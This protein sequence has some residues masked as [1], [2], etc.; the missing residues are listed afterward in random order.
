MANLY[1]TKAGNDTTGDGSI[2][3]PWLT[4]GKANSSSLSPADIVNIGDG[5]YAENLTAADS[6][7][8]GNVIT[9]KAINSRLASIQAQI[10]GNGQEYLT[11]DGIKYLGDGTAQGSIRGS[12]NAAGL[13]NI[14]W[15][16]CEIFGARRHAFDIIPS[17]D[18]G[19]QSSY[20]DV[21]IIQNCLMDQCHGCLFIHA[22]NS[23]YL[24]NEMR[25][26]RSHTT[27]DID[28]ARPM[29]VDNLFQGN[30]CHSTDV[31]NTGTSHVDCVQIFHN[32]GEL[33]SGLQILK[34]FFEVCVQGIFMTA[35][36][37]ALSI[38]DIEIKNNVFIEPDTGATVT[39]LAAM[40]FYGITN[41]DIDHNHSI[42]KRDNLSTHIRFHGSKGSGTAVSSG[43][44]KN[45]TFVR[46]GS[47]SPF[48]A[49][50]QDV[51]ISSNISKD[52]SS[53]I[54]ADFNSG[55]AIDPQLIDSAGTG[56][57]AL[58]TYLEV[59][60]TWRPVVSTSRSLNAASD[61]GDLGAEIAVDGGGPPTD[62]TPPVITL[63]GAAEINIPDTD[64]S[65]TDAG[66]TCSDN[67]DGELVMTAGVHDTDGVTANL[68]TPGTYTYD[69]D[70]DDAAA[71]SAVQVTRTVNIIATP[72]TPA[73]RYLV[74]IQLA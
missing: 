46:G 3:T 65:Y 13:N 28:Y 38:D 72:P 15:N 47:G 21:L 42:F 51:V 9:W 66:A 2:G 73:T 54:A 35:R 8:A 4:L 55:V 20:A 18:A 16:D 39:T 59:D 27:G 53:G 6:G 23:S 71:N 26:M 62:T 63:I 22:Q 57:G 34:N 12:G 17:G 58:G 67:L 40:T 11:F 68:G 10:V 25:D 50:A 49:G 31:A 19:T 14:T 32:N 43:T 56:Y 60:A 64:V 45:C 61:G 1:V 33:N 37:D 69:W 7:T 44:C 74:T 5:H 41:L 36:N 70:R 29:G 48:P 24:N 30:W 52:L